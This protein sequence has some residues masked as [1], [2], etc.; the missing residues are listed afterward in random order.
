MFVTELYI[1]IL[2]YFLEERKEGTGRGGT[3]TCGCVHILALVTAW[4]GCRVPMSQVAHNPGTV[5]STI[6]DTVHS[7]IITDVLVHW[8]A[9]HR[10]ARARAQDACSLQQAVCTKLNFSPMQGAWA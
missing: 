5:W 6:C 3:G 4:V 1:S 10:V 7:R 8:G 2:S 9:A